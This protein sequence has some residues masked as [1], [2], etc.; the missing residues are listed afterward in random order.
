MCDCI[1]PCGSRHGGRHG[2]GKFRINDD[3]G[4]NQFIINHHIL[5]NLL[6]I[7]QRTHIGDFTGSSGCGRDGHQG[8]QRMPHFANSRIIAN[9]SGIRH[10]H[11]NGLSQ[12]NTASSAHCNK[13]VHCAAP[14][15]PGRLLHH[16]VGRIR[17]D[18]VK[19]NIRDIGFFHHGQD[20]FCNA[21]RLH[22]CVIHNHDLFCAI[23]F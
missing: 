8:K 19:H 6:G 17:D 13:Y 3:L 18:T 14:G 12:V 22:A 11:I 15:Q 1:H 23:S 5:Y 21:C 2:P 4:R 10:Q 16:F 7:C 20:L 9:G